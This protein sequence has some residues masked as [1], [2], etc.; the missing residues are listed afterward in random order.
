MLR[1]YA[2]FL[3]PWPAHNIYNPLILFYAW[4]V[5]GYLSSDSH[6]HLLWVWGKISLY[7]NLSQNFSLLSR[8]LGQ[9]FFSWQMMLPH[10]AQE[11][12]STLGSKPSTNIEF[13]G[14][15]LLHFLVLRSGRNKSLLMIRQALYENALYCDSCVKLKHSYLYSTI[16]SLSLY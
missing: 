16:P 5:A 7:L 9:Q 15:F 10:R 14:I 13:F 2:Y 8:L 12:L 3:I 1:L 11:I 6:T 4:H